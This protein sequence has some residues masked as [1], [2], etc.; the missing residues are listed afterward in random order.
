MA[1]QQ[2]FKVDK[3]TGVILDSFVFDPETDTIPDEC[4]L[5]W[6][7]GFLNPVYDWKLNQWVE[8]KSPEE[9]L[10]FRREM[11]INE[12]K[13]ECNLTIL[14]GFLSL[15]GNSYGFNYHDQM[16]FTQQKLEMDNDSAITMVAWKSLNNGVVYHTREE[17]YRVM[18]DAKSH[19][20]T[21]IA[22]Y[23][24]LEQRVLAAQ[25]PEEI[26]SITWTSLPTA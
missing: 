26:E 12:L 24:Q 9:V 22:K 3:D 18:M 14:N 23:W 2:Y 20:N 11:K 6:G 10:A 16:N 7:Q 1:E 15:N 25:S 4:V 21:N 17:F 5:G 8:S 19:K 13:E